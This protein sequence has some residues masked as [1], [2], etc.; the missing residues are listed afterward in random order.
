MISGPDNLAQSPAP[1]A[2]SLPDVMFSYS[3]KPVPAASPTQKLEPVGVQQG[4][5]RSVAD[6]PYCPLAR[7]A[8]AS[9][10]GGQ[11]TC[12][13]A[14]RVEGQPVGVYRVQVQGLHSA[15]H[16]A[17]LLLQL[18]L[19]M[20]KPEPMPSLVRGADP[21]R[22]SH[23]YTDRSEAATVAKML[24]LVGCQRALS[25]LR[26]DSTSTRG[27]S[28]LYCVSSSNLNMQTRTQRFGVQ[29]ADPNKQE[30]KISLSPAAT[31]ASLIKST[32]SSSGRDVIQFCKASLN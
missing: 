9:T 17:G 1:A 13:T 12:V 29:N 25:S 15:A 11:C 28:P 5:C 26:P 10:G 31:K 32:A 24:S 30:S 16:N 21:P 20:L 18:R 14:W 23:R 19:F 8:I 7:L 4:C 3:A 27:S 2:C 22:S 6:L